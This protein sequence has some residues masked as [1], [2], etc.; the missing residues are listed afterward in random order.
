MSGIRKRVWRVEGEYEV[1]TER[2]YMDG[3][4]PVPLE[5]VLSMLT[6]APLPGWRWGPVQVH[7]VS[8][9]WRRPSTAEERDEWDALQ[10][11]RAEQDEW[12]ERAYHQ[13]LSAKS[14]KED[15]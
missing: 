8:L 10:A 9:S 4:G 6:D 5:D 12:W 14:E 1:I 15:G 3:P 7:S 13:Q 2:L 11:D